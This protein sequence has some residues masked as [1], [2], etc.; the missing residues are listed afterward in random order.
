[1]VELDERRQE[2]LQQARAA[3]EAAHQKAVERSARL[4]DRIRQEM[5]ETV[6]RDAVK[7]IAGYIDDVWNG[8]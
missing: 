3:N 7:N 2:R 5:D 8:R 4:A 1:M 6:T